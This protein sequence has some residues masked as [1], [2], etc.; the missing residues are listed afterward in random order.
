[1]EKQDSL[2]EKK[3]VFY[4]QSTKA[5]CLSDIGVQLFH[6]LLL[7]VTGQVGVCNKSYG[8]ISTLSHLLPSSAWL[9][10]GK[11]WKAET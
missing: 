1:M 5:W 10:G 2:G 9:P 3:G 11:P 6:S 4:K 7:L 8:S